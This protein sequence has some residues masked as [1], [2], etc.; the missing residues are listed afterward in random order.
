MD[1]SRAFVW[2]HLRTAAYVASEA[3]PVLRDGAVLVIFVVFV[4][5]AAGVIPL[6]PR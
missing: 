3:G 4:L 1:H 2:S 5:I 6:T